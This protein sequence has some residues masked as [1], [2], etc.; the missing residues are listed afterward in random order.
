M[1][2]RRR[3]AALT[4]HMES[5]LVLSPTPINLMATVTIDVD[6]DLGDSAARDD[7]ATSELTADLTAAVRVRRTPARQPPLQPAS[8]DTMP[9]IPQVEVSADVV[10]RIAVETA[11]ENSEVSV[12]TDF[13]IIQ[14]VDEFSVPDRVGSAGRFEPDD[15]LVARRTPTSKSDD[16]AMQTV[17]AAALPS[18]ESPDINARTSARPV[19]PV[20]TTGTVSSDRTASNDR[21]P[22][23]DV[24][25]TAPATDEPDSVTDQAADTDVV[26]VRP[27]ASRE[28]SVDM[29]Q[30]SALT[31]A[32][33]SSEPGRSRLQPDAP[34][35]VTN[36]EDIV[37]RPVTDS[38][39]DLAADDLNSVVVT[40]RP[41]STSAVQPAA[42]VTQVADVETTRRTV[43]SFVEDIPAVRAEAPGVAFAAAI[44]AE[45]LRIV[46]GLA[47]V[48]SVTDVTESSVEE[49]EVVT[50]ISDTVEDSEESSEV[51]ESEATIKVET[52]TE[53]LSSPAV[54]IAPDVQSEIQQ[55]RQ[56]HG[57]QPELVISPAAHL[58]VPSAL[59][60]VRI[61]ESAG[62]TGLE[63]ISSIWFGTFG[64]VSESDSAKSA[65][66]TSTASMSQ[67]VFGDATRLGLMLAAANHAGR[68]SGS[69]VAFSDI[70]DDPVNEGAVYSKERRRRRFSVSRRLPTSFERLRNAANLEDTVDERASLPCPSPTCDTLFSDEA[71]M[72]LLFQGDG[73]KTS[74]GLDANWPSGGLVLGT[75]AL[76][77]SGT[78][79][80][81]NNR[82][83]TMRPRPAA[84]RYSGET[85]VFAD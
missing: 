6:N 40:V 58:T 55:P 49:A 61:A 68:R 21:V 27:S 33:T 30:D 50:V 16:Q 18:S 23:A 14:L 41:R 17:D 75:A 83:A 77:A 22:A 7:L 51:G 44:S 46:S 31:P 5:R 81:R 37:A 8:T 60:R 42:E 32:G 1:N 13:V 85:L 84:P 2:Q 67:T 12:E 54:L 45:P 65:I 35:D 82:R 20:Q 48:E 36:A 39:V 9:V 4:E 34:T 43:A 69:L 52:P 24:A 53:E 80:V 64:F 10:D 11:P 73:A 15:A 62:T 56:T 59:P 78:Q 3:L 38:P 70:V 25:S 28:T 79:R 74:D 26:I 71:M 76:A 63:R 72:T 66:G 47:V 57:D 19:D 29:P